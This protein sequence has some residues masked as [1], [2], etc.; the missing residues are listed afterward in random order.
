MWKRKRRPDD[1]AAAWASWLDHVD[2]VMT[3]GAELARRT[4]A[5]G[6]NLTGDAA[7]ARRLYELFTALR[8]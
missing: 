5:D 3:E 2:A 7:R 4:D 6:A 8:A 1:L